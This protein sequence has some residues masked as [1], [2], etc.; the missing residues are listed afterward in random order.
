MAKIDVLLGKTSQYEVLPHF[1]LKLYEAFVRLGHAC[2]LL[3][4]DSFL[5]A[6]STSPPDFTIGFNGGPR[7][8]DHLLYCEKFQIPHVSLLVDPP[9]SFLYLI[10]SS[11]TMIG[12]DDKTGC[13]F[14][15]NLQ[16]ENTFFLPH[17]VE[18]ELCCHKNQ[19]KDLDVVMLATFIDY[20]NRWKE[21]KQKYPASVR[22]LMEQIVEKTFDEPKT[23]FIT[24]FD[25][26]HKQTSSRFESK[27]LTEIFQDLELYIKGR[28]RAELAKTV[29]SSTLHIFGGTVDR[30]NWKSYLG[31][32]HPNIYVHN[33][34]DYQQAL[35]IIKR[36]K[37]ILNPSLKNK[38]GAHE[39]I[40][41]GL[42]CETLVITNESQYLRESFSDRQGIVFFDPARVKS[43]DHTINTYLTHEAVRSAEVKK[44]KQIV[45][46]NHTWDHRVKVILEAISPFLQK[47]RARFH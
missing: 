9:Y 5:E 30:S 7:D 26:A 45:M 10:E 24:A 15:N 22:R 44:G 16:F 35:E 37:V 34:V 36:S 47:K 4:G 28:N 43:L 33:P 38:E 12:C 17:A 20:E 32:K 6:I 40:F 27:Q 31:K 3:N 23:S 8:P 39:R 46:K 21:W 25:E 19:K 14:L 29:P 11:Y 42:A 13:T 18:P 41:S 1:T 2:R